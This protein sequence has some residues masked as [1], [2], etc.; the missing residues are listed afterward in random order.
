MA[1]AWTAFKDQLI[2]DSYE[3]GVASYD[4]AHHGAGAAFNGV[5]T[6]YVKAAYGSQRRRQ[7]R[8]RYP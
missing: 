2:T 3:L 6:L 7:E 1:T 5:T 4:R 8:I